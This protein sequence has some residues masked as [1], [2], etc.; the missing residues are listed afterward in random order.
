MVSSTNFRSLTN[1]WGAGEK[2]HSFGR[3]SSA[4]GLGF[5]DM[6]PKLHTLLPVRQ[7]VCDA[8]AGG[9]RHVELGE[10]ALRQSWE[11]SSVNLDATL[12]A[13][14]QAVNS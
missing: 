8:P 11:D 14:Q 2:E 5:R 4:D 6:F 13:L 3:G 7:E 12:S 9:V 1:W 10:L